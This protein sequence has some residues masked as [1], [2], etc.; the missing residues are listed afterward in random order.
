MYVCTTSNVPDKL[1]LTIK[2]FKFAAFAIK[3]D[4]VM[5]EIKVYACRKFILS[6]PLL[7]TV[8]T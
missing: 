3:S 4:E 8:W 7:G 6:D 2:N 1:T 5:I